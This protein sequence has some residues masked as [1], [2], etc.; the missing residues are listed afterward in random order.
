MTSHAVSR[1]CLASLVSRIFF[2]VTD[3][4]C[5]LPGFVPCLHSFYSHTRSLLC[6]VLAWGTLGI[7]WTARF[8]FYHPK[9]CKK[10]IKRELWLNP[11]SCK[12][13]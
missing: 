11:V 1:G 10:K 5:I 2:C 7:V 3:F 9:K 12:Q 4:T 13:S 6:S 8:I